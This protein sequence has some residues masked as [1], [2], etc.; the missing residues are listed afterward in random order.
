MDCMSKGEYRRFVGG[1]TCIFGSANQ[2]LWPEALALC[3]ESDGRLVTIRNAEEDR[4]MQEI[5]NVC[6]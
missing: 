3:V 1:N 5:C 4:A 2:L 6:V